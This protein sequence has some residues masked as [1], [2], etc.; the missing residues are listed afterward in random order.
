MQVE[1]QSPP[2]AAGKGESRA[3]SDRRELCICVNPAWSIVFP[4]K[5]QTWVLVY[6][7]HPNPAQ[8]PCVAVA[9]VVPRRLNTQTTFGK[10]DLEQRR[11]Q[12]ATKRCRKTGIKVWKVCAQIFSGKVFVP[13][14]AESQLHSHWPGWSWSWSWSWTKPCSMQSRQVDTDMTALTGVSSAVGP[15]TKQ[16]C[17]CNRNVFVG[18]LCQQENRIILHEFICILLSL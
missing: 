15:V 11:Q 5:N 10:Y 17:M 18:K 6:T 16:I 13:V 14:V 4:T 2:W 12:Q 7:P 9:Q 1:I 8:K 3:R